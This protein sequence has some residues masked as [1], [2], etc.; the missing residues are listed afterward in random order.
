MSD[1]S[2][3]EEDLFAAALALPA[4]ERR[5]FLEKAL[6]NDD[7]LRSRVEALLRAHN[8]AGDLLDAAPGG[9]IR[10]AL[11]KPPPKGKP[12]TLIGRYKLLQKLG[13]GGCGVVYMAVQEEPV[14]RRVALKVVKLGMNTKEVIAR[15][16]AERQALALMDHP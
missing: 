16:E 2:R 15:F 3:R 14:C 12:G 10:A 6:G 8:E 9:A 4:A 7:A 13:E 1:F 11:A 5:V